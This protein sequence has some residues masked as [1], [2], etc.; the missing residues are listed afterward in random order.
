M[1]DYYKILEVRDDTSSEVI[2]KAYKALCNK[3]HPDKNPS[4]KAKWA[5][6]KMQELNHAY[7]ILSDSA[8]RSAY[9]KRKKVHIIQIF[10]EDGVIGMTKYWLN[11]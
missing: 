10:W 6:K 9:D 3:Y 5:T 2:E 8:K 1:K 7:S 11:R 4:G